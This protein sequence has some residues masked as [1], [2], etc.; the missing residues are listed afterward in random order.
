[1]AH[2]NDWS[3]QYRLWLECVLNE[4]YLRADRFPAEEWTTEAPYHHVPWDLMVNSWFYNNCLL[5]SVMAALLSSKA[6]LPC[7]IG[8]E[9]PVDLNGLLLHCVEVM[10]NMMEQ[11]LARL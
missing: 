11:V 7:R 10:E 5:L 3:S 8:I 2:L 9:P 6:D 1:M 4:P